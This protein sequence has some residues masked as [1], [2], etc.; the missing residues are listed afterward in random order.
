MTRYVAFLR[1][2]NVGG[3]R[4]KMDQLLEYFEALGFANVSTFIASGNVIFESGEKKTAVLEE[5]IEK[6]LE[7]VLGYEVAA[8]V[9]TD[10]QVAKIAERDAFATQKPK[11]GDTTHVNFLRHAPDAA[12]RK[13]ILALSNDE[14]VLHLHRSELYWLRCGRM[15]DSTITDK[16]FRQAFGKGP[17]TVRNL[18]TVR[19]LAAILLRSP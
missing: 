11:E 16:E 14:D 3:H 4:V 9:R 18:N 5:K 7:T 2:L 15:L 17:N 1:G 12:T 8:F 10:A 13:R 19:R 6:A